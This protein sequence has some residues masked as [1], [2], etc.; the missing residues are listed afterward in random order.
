MNRIVDRRRRWA[1]VFV[2]LLLLALVLPE[3]V[4][5]DT[6]YLPLMRAERPVVPT[7]AG[8]S[9]A[10]ITGEWHE[11]CE[12]VRINGERREVCRPGSIDVDHDLW[13]QPGDECMDADSWHA[14]ARTSDPDYD[15]MTHAINV[16][17]RAEGERFGEVHSDGYA[18]TWTLD[19]VYWACRKDGVPP[20]G[21]TIP[22]SPP[23]ELE[24]PAYRAPVDRR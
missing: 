19:Y 18:R 4:R 3:S 7:Q 8:L 22:L 11:V 13:F 5:A 10:E 15:P 1:A 16:S 24:I 12:I 9:Y 20:A 6:L 17:I 23:V 21:G 2:T 14:S